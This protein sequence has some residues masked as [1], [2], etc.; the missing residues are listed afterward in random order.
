MSAFTQVDSTCSSIANKVVMALREQYR[1]TKCE[2]M[3][4]C[5]LSR[6]FSSLSCVTSDLD[7]NLKT[8]S[9]PAR[10]YDTWSALA[11]ALRLGGTS[12]EECIRPS[13]LSMVKQVVQVFDPGGYEVRFSRNG[14]TS[15]QLA[16]GVNK[17][18]RTSI[19]Y[20]LL[21][22]LLPI[23]CQLPSIKQTTIQLDVSSIKHALA[24]K[25]FDPSAEGK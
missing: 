22:E 18:G 12:K 20:I 16:S 17:K 1:E 19:V 10:K 15:D 8:C 14:Q 7:G 9:F 2:G 23:I 4:I 3:A 11:S 25:G 24:L 6:N 21:I 13:E 5:T